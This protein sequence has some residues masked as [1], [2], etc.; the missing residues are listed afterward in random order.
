M[1]CWRVKRRITSWKFCSSRTIN[2]SCLWLNRKF[3][4]FHFLVSRLKKAFCV[5]LIKKHNA[6]VQERWPLFNSMSSNSFSGRCGIHLLYQILGIILSVSIYQILGMNK[7]DANLE[8]DVKGEPIQNE[9]SSRAYTLPRFFLT[10]S[11]HQ[12]I[13]RKLFMF[14]QIEKQPRY[15]KVTLRNSKNLKEFPCD[16]FSKTQWMN[17][18][19]CQKIHLKKLKSAKLWSW[20]SRVWKLKLNFRFSQIEA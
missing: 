7:P 18:Q 3:A 14:F 20:A 19:K 8:H 6:E 13:W 16:T 5:C 4:I 1:S 15:S 17:D 10:A 9:N 2:Q 11:S 12:K